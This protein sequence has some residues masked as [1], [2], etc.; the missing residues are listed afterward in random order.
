M[1]FLVVEFIEDQKNLVEVVPENWVEVGEDPDNET[2]CFWPN[3]LKNADSL[4]KAIIK[5]IASN[6]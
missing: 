4:R 1:V 2:I 6:K 3:H 5:K